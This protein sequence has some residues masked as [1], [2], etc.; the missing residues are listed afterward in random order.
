MEVYLLGPLGLCQ[1][2]LAVVHYGGAHPTLNLCT[3]GT[4]AGGSL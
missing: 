4:Q 2:H 1:K 3:W